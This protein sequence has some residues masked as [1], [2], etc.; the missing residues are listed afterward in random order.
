MGPSTETKKGA[1]VERWPFVEVSLTVK[2]AQ[3]SSN[4][5]IWIRL[6]AV[7]KHLYHFVP[8]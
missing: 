1:I 6:A 8:S 7:M 3:G 4:S 2:L 5:P